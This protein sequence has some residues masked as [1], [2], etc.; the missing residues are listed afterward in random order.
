MRAR[1]E[2]RPPER[3]VAHYVLERD[4]ARRIREAPSLDRARIY[5]EV[6][7]QLFNALP[8]HPQHE[9][10][11]RPG[12]R[13]VQHS[14][15]YLSPFFSKE[16]TYLEIGCGDAAVSVAAAASVR[17][18][19]AVDV[20]DKLLDDGPHPPNF[21]FVKLQ[22]GTQLPF[23]SSTIDV[24]S[25]D[26]LIEHLHPDDVLVHLQEVVR[27]LKPGGLYICTT[28]SALTGPH[29]IS[30]YFGFVANG[31]HIKEYNYRDLSV[32]FVTAGFKRLRLAI[33]AFGRQV[34]LPISLGILA[35]KCFSSFP[36]A[37][38][39]YLARTRA[40]QRLFGVNVVGVK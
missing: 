24:C 22:N 37:I 20:Q 16:A 26:Q 31:L 36:L 7:D 12:A 23:D 4:L 15:R 10:K 11:N 18:A 9:K 1:G 5:T 39:T 38:R 28:P 40:A 33:R 2:K 21:R 6:Y 32:L 17:Q 34:L 30:T 13:P 8:D 27:I 29:D 3:L 35:E 25:S 19:I 14:L